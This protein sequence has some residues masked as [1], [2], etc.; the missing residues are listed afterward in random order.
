M[1][2]FLLTRMLSIPYP[3][4]DRTCTP[5]LRRRGRLSAYEQDSFIV[6][7]EAEGRLIGARPYGCIS[8][9]TCRETSGFE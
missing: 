5:P 3:P 1:W 2:H 8:I 4:A 7:R 9:H 6:V